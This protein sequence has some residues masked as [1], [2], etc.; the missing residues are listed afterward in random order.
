MCDLPDEKTFQPPIPRTVIAKTREVTRINRSSTYFNEF[1]RAQQNTM[2]GMPEQP[3][4]YTLSTFEVATILDEGESKK[5][6]DHHV[7]PF[8]YSP[9]YR[10]LHRID[11]KRFAG[12]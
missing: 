12:F 8:L 11:H 6:F 2:T 7:E 3:L 10:D 9:S 1:F 5:N 4:E